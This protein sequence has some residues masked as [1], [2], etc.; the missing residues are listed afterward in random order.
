[1]ASAPARTD[2]PATRPARRFRLGDRLG[3]VVR[4][5][6]AMISGRGGRSTPG[7]SPERA[8]PSRASRATYARSVPDPGRLCTT[9]PYVDGRLAGPPVAR[10][11]RGSA[12]HEALMEELEVL[13]DIQM[14][15]RGRTSTR[16]GAC[17][18]RCWW[19]S[20]RSRGARRRRCSAGSSLGGARLRPSNGRRSRPTWTPRSAGSFGGSRRPDGRL[21]PPERG[22][23]GSLIRGHAIGELE[24]D[25]HG[26]K[27]R[28]R[29]RHHSTGSGP[30]SVARADS[31][32]DRSV[33]SGPARYLREC[34]LHRC[35]IGGPTLPS[36]AP[37]RCAAG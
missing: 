28:S 27:Q 29:I 14:S 32:T 15:E 30:L 31:S 21:L 2:A 19:A 33:S 8:G 36:H 35:P 12:R 7:P 10:V 22:P 20:R 37:V 3:R 9:P 16:W 26:C 25:W 23:A 6:L 18:T 4:S 13:R 17:C 1:M 24:F 11:R 34:A 5:V